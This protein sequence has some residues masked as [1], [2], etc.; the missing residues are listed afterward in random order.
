MSDGYV[1]RPTPELIEHANVARFM[2]RHGISDHRE[3]IRRSTDAIEWFWQAAIE[4]LGIA[5]SRPYDTLLDTGRGIPWPRWFLGGAINLADHC[6]DRHARSP[7][8]DQ[9]AII[10][11]GEDGA[12]RRLSYAELNAE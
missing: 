4:D 10:W 12:V 9:T 7:R 6:L 5:F 1:W 3:L 2:R 11:E 8:R